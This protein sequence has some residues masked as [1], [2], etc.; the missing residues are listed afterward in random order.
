MSLSGW[1]PVK[2]RIVGL[3]DD[4]FMVIVQGH[5]LFAFEIDDVKVWLER[6]G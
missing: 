2:E 3:D 4:I 6:N 1:G 5:K